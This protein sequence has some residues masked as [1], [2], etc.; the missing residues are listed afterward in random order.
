MNSIDLQF[1]PFLMPIIGAGI[2]LTILAAY[3]WRQSKTAPGTDVFIVLLGL[4]AW[5]CFTYAFELITTNPS[6]MLFWVK[7]EWISIALL[8]VAWLLFALTYAGYARWVTL[9]IITLLSVIPAIMI[10]LAW[11]TPAHTLIYADPGV[12]TV[13]A[14]VYFSATRG[15]AYIFH[16]TYSYLLV[17][18]ATFLIIRVWWRSTG[19]QRRL[20]LVVVIGA[21]LPILSNVIYQIGLATGRPINVDLTVPAFAFSAVLFA[22][23]WFRLH[24]FELVPELGRPISTSGRID[25]AAAALS[26]QT[27]SLNLVSLAMSLLFFLALAPIFT[28]LLRG[29]PAQR[30]LMAAYILLYLLLLAVTIRRDDRYLTRATGLTLVYLGLALLDLRV[31][32]LT[33]VIGLFLVTYAAFAAVLLPWR[34]TLVMLGIGLAGV[35]LVPPIQDPNIQRDIYSLGYLLLSVSMTAGMV[36]VALSATRRDIRTLLQTSRDISQVLEDER[37]QL[38]M[39][40]AERTRALETSA[41]VSRQLST[42]L[43][44]SRLVREVVEQLRDAFAYYHVHIFLWD[45]TLGALRMVGG[46][47]EAGQAMLIMGHTIQPEQGL[48]GRAFSTNSPVVVPNVNED[49]GWL[50]NRLLPGT[51]AEIAVPITFGDEV[52]GVLD[53]QDSE[54]GGLGLEDS[55]LLQTIAGQL[56]VALRN[57]RLVTQIQQEA[58]QEALIN[59]INRKIAQTTDIDGAMRVAVTELSRALDTREAAIRLEINGANG[60]DQ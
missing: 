18:L 4:S 50:P 8:P 52:L 1:T 25:P 7:L 11:T 21:L 49:L 55:Q 9:P 60:H 37:S 12:R 26:T 10:I 24:W 44:Q 56:A 30:P 22:W 42:I 57:A 38:E 34:L 47:G 28:L 17:L 14:L 13:D 3:A 20:A 45:D 32:G 19:V 54:V 16:V 23:G 48:V 29:G 41:V 33:P 6:T 58:E 51:Q 46:T 43:D 35:L 31:S 39:R 53:A 27:R 15:P 59:A 40:V 5:W 36:V 2:V